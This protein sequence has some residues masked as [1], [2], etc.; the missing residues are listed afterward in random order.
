MNQDNKVAIVTGGASGFGASIA[1][2][3]GQSGVAV[4]VA[5]LHAQGAQ[6]IAD[7]INGGGGRASAIACDVS[8][9]QDVRAMVDAAVRELGGLHVMVNNAGATH[10]NKPALQV[11]EAE[12]DRV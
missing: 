12:F 8:R 7:E 3:L 1:M 9:E 10:R 11:S 4:M 2:R 6:R 5:D